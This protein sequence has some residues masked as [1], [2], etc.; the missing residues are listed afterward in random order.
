VPVNRELT[1]G[2]LLGSVAVTR[3]AQVLIAAWTL[4]LVYRLRA[5]APEW[6]FVCALVGGMLATPYVHLDDLAMLG[7]AAWLCMRASPARGTWAYA[8]ALVVIIEGEPIWGPVPVITAEV[9][10]LV[11]LSLVALKTRDALSLPQIDARPL[12]LHPRR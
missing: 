8:L 6:V 7:L 4:F 5:R 2:H 11:L 1:L 10:A 3:A 12:E 9:V